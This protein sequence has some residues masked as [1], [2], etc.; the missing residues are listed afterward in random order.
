MHCMLLQ[1]DYERSEQEYLAALAME[2]KAAY[3]ANLGVLYHR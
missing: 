3:L 2:R 1:E